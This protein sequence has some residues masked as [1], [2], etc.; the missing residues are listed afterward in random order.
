MVIASNL[1]KYRKSAACIGSPHQLGETLYEQG[2]AAILAEIDIIAWER[3][4]DLLSHL[5]GEFAE[6]EDIAD[7]SELEDDKI[8]PVLINRLILKANGKDFKGKCPHCPK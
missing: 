5:R 2:A 3:A 1:G 6:L 8:T 4:R 7:W